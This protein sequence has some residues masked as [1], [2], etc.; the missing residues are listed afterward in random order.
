VTIPLHRGGIAL[1][2]RAPSWLI[3]VVLLAMSAVSAPAHAADVSPFWE[4][5]GGSASGE[6]I[7]RTSGPKAVL[8]TSL[9]VGSDGLPVVVYTEYPDRQAAQGPIVV[10]GWNGSA[11]LT[12]SP[13]GGIAQGYRPQIRISPGGAI[14]VAWLQDDVDGNAEIHLRVRPAGGATFDALADSDSPGGISGSNPGITFPFSLAVGADDRPAIAFL[15]WALTGIELITET[16]AIIDGTLQTYVRRWNGGAWEF[17]GTDF[18]TGGGASSAASFDTPIGAVVHE[19]DTPALTLDA[20]G[21]PVVAFAYV[22][23]IDGVVQGNTDLYATRWNPGTQRWEPVGPPVPAGDSAAG[24]G[25]AGGISQSE[26]VSLNPS[27]ASATGG[28]FALAWEEE[29]VAGAALYVW[30]RVWN[31]ADTWEELDGS[32]TDSGFTEPDTLNGVPQI[33]VGADGRFVVAWTAETPSLPAPQI[34]VL[35]WNGVGAWQQVGLQSASDAGISDAAVEAF[36]PALALTPDGGPAT[37]GVPAVAWVDARDPDSPQ[38]FLRRLFTGDVAALSVT[39]VGN[40]S[41][42]SGPIG[43]ACDGEACTGEFPSGSP[44]RLTATPET[45]GAFAGWGGACAASGTKRD[46]TV[47]LAADASVTAAFKHYRVSVAVAKPATVIG[48]GTLG[49]V[50]GPDIDCGGG[51]AGTCFTDVPQGTRLALVA[52]AAPGNR[53]LSW[54]GGPC[55]G[56]TSAT[57][58]FTVKANTSTTALFR[59]ISAVQVF[60]DGNGSGTVTGS[61]IA[62]GGDCR[63]QYFSGTKVTLTPKATTGSIFR[64]WA[65]DLCDGQASGKCVFVA[66]GTN[67]SI[68]VAN[69]STTATFERTRHTLAVRLRPN[70]SVVSDPLPGGLV[71]ECGTAGVAC[72]ATL[73]YGTPVLLRA[74]PDPGLAFVKWSGVSC[75]K[76]GAANAS[77]AFVLK[78]NVTATPSYRPRTL[79]TVTKSGTGAGTVKG[80]GISCPADC[81]GVLLDGKPGTLTATPATG[82][83]FVGFSGDCTPSGSTCAIVPVGDRQSVTAEFAIQLRTLQI[84]LVGSGSVGGPG[85]SCDAA[86]AP[87]APML[88]YGTPATLSPVPAPGF[89]FT[90]WSQACTGTAACKPAMTVDRTVTATFKPVF[91]VAVTR[92]GDSAASG[93]ISAT[94]IKCGVDCAQDYLAGTTVTF[95]RTAPPTGRTFRWLGDC[96]FRGTNASCAITMDA[97]KSVIAD[98][99][100]RELGLTVNVTGPGTVTGAG[101]PCGGLDC[102]SIAPYGTPVVLQALP[103]SSP[104]GEFVG[105]TGCTATA[106]TNCSVTLT[107]NRTVAAAFRPAVSALEVKAAGADAGVPLAAKAKRQYSAIATFSDGSTQDVTTQATWT[108]GN[109]SVVTVLATTGLATG[110]GFGDTTLTAVFRGASDSLAVAADTLTGVRV[111]CE[112]YG[113]SGGSLSCLPAGL[114]FEVECRATGAFTHA[115]AHDV[116]D[117]A[118]WT[119]SSKSIARSLGLAQFGDQPAVA[120]FR[121]FP[122]T[123]AIKATVG[124]IVSASTIAPGNGWTV[125]GVTLTVTEVSVAPP[126]GRVIRGTPV[127]LQALASLGGATCTSP[128]RDF[129]LLTTWETSDETIA[130]VNFF[131]LVDPLTAGAVTIHWTYPPTGAEGDVSITVQP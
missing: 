84:R 123:A 110:V 92:Q 46:C 31:G 112:P 106:G 60:K 45:G 29:P 102:V 22:T 78:G 86:A 65:G 33:A 77:C 41:V 131:G 97:N 75:L 5:L 98:Y 120:S 79:V 113:E 13:P 69:Q 3:L 129:S 63:Q 49:T 35:R 36:A 70:G 56:R 88:P 19:A 32:A 125:Q 67:R 121:I 26:G 127:Q 118:V 15:A 117:Q 64:G 1:T 20:S 91:G 103:S 52:T 105:W 21:E 38:V 107:A 43:L 18:D 104:R 76:G 99:S 10:K 100:R 95:S 82:S 14:Y 54:A 8:D 37:A 83:T 57:C 48:Q 53:F 61:G 96:G 11:W 39:L 74:V 111:A 71:I 51:G 47:T 25:G 9:A 62:C 124:S 126:P 28:R 12:L 115:G 40:G 101:A 72:G 55:S 30:V 44:V 24:R 116:T 4:E 114:G 58:E 89:A 50:T 6:G 42:T 59:G 93:T 108:S 16:P 27:F 7:S 66:S 17:V 87:C 85:F 68:T 94:G 109:T 34:F 90:G 80:P 119:S 2:G 23:T 122:G 128:P 130:D 81:A 73:D